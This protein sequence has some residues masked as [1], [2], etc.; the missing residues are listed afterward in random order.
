MAYFWTGTVL[1]AGVH[2]FSLLL[3]GQRDALKARFGERAWK[4]G[5]S[6]VALAGLALMIRGFLLSRSGPAAADLLYY[7]ADSLRPVT[8]LMVL[9]AFVSLGAAHGKGYIKLWIKHPMSI[10]FALWSA[11]HL[12][13]NGKRADVYLFG[14]FWPWR[15]SA[16]C[17]LGARQV[18]SHEPRIRSDV[19]A[20][21]GMALCRLPAGLPP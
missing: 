7:P 15:S 18:S 3:P 21:I 2:L 16:S 1:F 5:Y 12:L 8:M 9:L 19:I 17:L 14:V 6:V 4:T 20:V 10:G 11:G 13:A